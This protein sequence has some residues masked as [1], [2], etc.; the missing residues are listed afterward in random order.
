MPLGLQNEAVLGWQAALEPHESERKKVKGQT[1]EQQKASTIRTGVWG[2]D[3]NR[4]SLQS[5]GRKGK[6]R[7][8]CHGIV[9]MASG[10]ADQGEITKKN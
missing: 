4:E 10:E 6:S 5:H 8:P 3:S 7:F 9:C 1:D 2:V